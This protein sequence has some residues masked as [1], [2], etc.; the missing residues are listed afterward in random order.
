MTTRSRYSDISHQYARDVV[1]G[2]ILASKW[3]K[4]ACTSYLN[5]LSLSS[6]GSRW[7]YDNKRA[8]RVCAFIESLRLADG[9]PFILQPWQVWLTCSLMGFVDETGTRKYIEALIMVPKGNGKSPWASAMG[10]W[11]AFLDGAKQSEVYCGAVSLSQAMEVFRPALSFVESQSAFAEL[12][13]QALKK[14]IFTLGGS[15][16]QPIIGK[17]RHGARPYL[18]ILDE[19]HQAISSDLYGTLKTGCNKTPNSLMLVISTAGIA[20]TQNTCYQLQQDAQKVLTGELPN[21]RLF[22]AIYC[23]DDTVAWN[24]DEALRMAN[25]NLGISND[26][27]KLRI[28]IAEATRNPA[29]ANNIKAMHLNIWSTAKSSWMNIQRWQDCGDPALTLESVKHLP[30]WIGADLASRLDLAS[31]ALVF[32]DDSQG[33]KP[34]Y[35]VFTRS[36]LPQD[37]VDEPENVH[38]QRW[39]EEGH[40]TATPDSSIDFDII[41][42]DTVKDIEQYKVRSLVYDS[43]HEGEYWSQRVVNL[44]GVTRVEAPTKSSVMTPAMKE[45]EAAVFDGRL[46]HNGDPILTWCIGNI[47]THE[48]GSGQYATPDKERPEFKLDAAIAVLTAMTQSLLAEPESAPLTA[49]DFFMFV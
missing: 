33:S 45:L 6:T 20:S 31:I 28:A 7:M 3:I 36:Y 32:R 23:S 40:L 15:R 19:L 43:G 30:C 12:G 39:V 9:S 21:E 2:T 26:A 16:F 42:D 8:D 46:H 18:A 34:H 22:A 1:D 38:Y 49:K 37:R 13:V 17:G 48:Y 44:S 4:L 11:Y 25:P 35:Y 24:S 10:L 5:D 27:E 41:L 47:V 14:S 29:H